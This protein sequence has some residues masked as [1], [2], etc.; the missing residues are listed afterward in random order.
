MSWLECMHGPR[1]NVLEN[2]GDYPID[3]LSDY[4][5]HELS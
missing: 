2:Y 1:E 3:S 5:H 4:W